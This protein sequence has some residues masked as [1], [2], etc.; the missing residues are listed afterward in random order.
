MVTQEMGFSMIAQVM[1]DSMKEKPIIGHNPMY[2]ILY[3]YNQF[4]DVLPSTYV[5]FIRSW[6]SKIV[7]Y[8]NKSIFPK[9]VLEH[10][11]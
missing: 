5:E 3:F 8:H 2:D 11:F 1:I 4:I 6:N 9:S 7:A 10:I